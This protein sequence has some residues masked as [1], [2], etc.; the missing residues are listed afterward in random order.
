MHFD[1][2]NKVHISFVGVVVANVVFVVAA[3]VLVSRAEPHMLPNLG[4]G[5]HP[6]VGARHFHQSDRREGY[7]G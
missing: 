2:P 6:G 4:Q 7:C 5:D 3:A 1:D